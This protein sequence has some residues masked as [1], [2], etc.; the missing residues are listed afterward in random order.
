MI[1]TLLVI[2]ATGPTSRQVLLAAAGR[3]VAT[4]SMA[5]RP[6]ALEGVKEAGE[7]VRGDVLLPATLGPA[8]AGVSAV[9]SVLGSKPTLGPDTMLSTGTANLV[10]ACRDAGVGRLVVVT[11]MGAGDSRGHGGWLYD[12]LLLPLLLRQVY[13]D[14]DRQE[15]LLRSSGLDWTIVRPAFLTDGPRTGTCRVVTDL[16]PKTRLTR[17]SRADVADYLVTAALTGR[18]VHGTVH[19]TM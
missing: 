13:A 18:D 8:C 10:R 1:P 9:V 16:T 11:G 15:Q 3:G 12:R 2:G 4:R 6:E 17:V 7:A 19:L 5:R 14:K